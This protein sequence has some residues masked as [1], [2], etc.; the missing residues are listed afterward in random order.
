MTNGGRYPYTFYIYS[1]QKMKLAEALSLRADLQKRV[2]EL[3]V[4]FKDSAKVQEGDTPAEDLA[5]LEVEL[6]MALAELEDLIYR[7]NATNM[8]TMHEGE[9]VTRMMARKDVLAMRVQLMQEVLR[10]VVEGDARYGRNEIKTVRVVDVPELRRKTDAAARELRELD[11][12]IQELNW[13]VDLI[14]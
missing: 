8:Q 3:K 13:A 14:E 10:H 2:N 7:I 12:K 4:R 11:M 6:N 5:A 9:T 1:N